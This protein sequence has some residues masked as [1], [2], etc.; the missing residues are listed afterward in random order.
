MNVLEA[1]I[2]VTSMQ[3][4]VTLKGVTPALATPDTQAMDLLAQVKSFF[5]VTVRPPSDDSLCFLVC[6]VLIV[7]ASFSG[8]HHK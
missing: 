7:V 8:F 6:E 4:A 3:H 2:G 1:L 5:L